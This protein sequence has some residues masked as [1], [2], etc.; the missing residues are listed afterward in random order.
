MIRRPPRSTL[1]PYTTLFR[2]LQGLKWE[3]VDL[4]AGTL[5]V[6]R[7]LSEPKG[8]YIFEA[9]KSGKGRQI[10]LSQRA[11]EALRSHRKRQLEEKLRAGALWQDHGLVF[12]SRVRS[13]ERRV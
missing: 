3:D 9:P 2:S 13:E 7:T 1:F 4:E 8:G 10:R 11:S 12:P 5:Q 6:R